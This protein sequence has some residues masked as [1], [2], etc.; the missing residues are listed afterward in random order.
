MVSRSSV[1]S[2]VRGL[3]HCFWLCFWLFG[4]LAF[5]TRTVM[6]TVSYSGKSK[7]HKTA[8]SGWSWRMPILS[9]ACSPLTR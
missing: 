6:A 5:I 1:E 7:V 3:F 4:C 9:V 2:F 8:S